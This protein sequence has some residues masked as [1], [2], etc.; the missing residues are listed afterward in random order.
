MPP[1]GTEQDSAQAAASPPRNPRLPEGINVGDAH[2]LSDLLLM[3]GGIGLGVTGLLLALMLFV[4]WLAP[5]L[6]YTLEQRLAAPYAE[7]LAHDG[8]QQAALRTLAESLAQAGA[9]EPGMTA[10]LHVVEMPEVNAMATLGGHVIVFSGLIEAMPSE[11]ALAFVIAHELAHVRLRHPV[12]AL[13]RGVF[14]GMALAALFGSSV[15]EGAVSS[16]LGGAG[17]LT[18]LAFSRAQEAE[19]DAAALAT[20]V[21]HYGHAAGAL[22]F[23]DSL[24]DRRSGGEE[25]SW[26]STHPHDDQRVQA[27]EGLARR[28]GWSLSGPLTPLPPALRQAEGVD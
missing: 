25:P 6:P 20:V 28:A 10:T 9:L 3:L 1:S 13:G 17:L 23:F 26:F 5:L 8:P 18:Q 21:Q 4:G 19:A 11:N 15:G 27:L 24:A 16:V 7:A 2:P 14:V 22:T 12:V